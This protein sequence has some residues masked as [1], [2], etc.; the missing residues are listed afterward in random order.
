LIFAKSNVCAIIRHKGAIA[1]V[2]C[3]LGSY[4]GDELTAKSPL[5][6]A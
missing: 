6:G 3:E 1:P 4:F 2:N 5:R